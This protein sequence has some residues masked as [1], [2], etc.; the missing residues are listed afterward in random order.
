MKLNLTK[1]ATRSQRLELFYS[2]FLLVVI[3]GLIAVNTILI[4]R[5]FRE[6]FDK[7]LRV[8]A[9][10]ANTVFGSVIEQNTANYQLVQSALENINENTDEISNILVVVPY[11]GRFQ[12]IA[13]ENEETRF[14]TVDSLLYKLVSDNRQSVAQLVDRPT[15]I[16]WNVATPLYDDEGELAAITSMDVSIAEAEAA[17]A[18][19]Q[20]QSVIILAITVVIV[21]LLLANHFR[22]VEY[23]QLFQKLKEADQLKSDFL[24]VATHEL[25]APMAVI[26]GQ[27][28]N[29]TDG[30]FGDVNDKVKTHLDDTIAQTDR[31]NN[32]VTD[33]LNV[34][35]IEQGRITFNITDF[36]PTKTIEMLIGQYKDKAAEKNI[37]LEYQKI[38]GVKIHGDESRFQVIISFK[39]S[40]IIF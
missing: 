14:Q 10:I 22:F 26:K 27:I 3:P 12:I 8:K 19:S 23:A 5:S 18:N 17:I 25:K 16:S 34:S 4:N 33:L 36:E 1:F 29:I 13:A 20:R 21:T 38:D 15:G 7:E 32:L 2:V 24:S 35:R 39:I 9:D 28:G 6:D 31:L 11:E 40:N 37:T 30:I